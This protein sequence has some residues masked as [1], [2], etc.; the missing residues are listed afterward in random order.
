M[1]PI[2]N[3]ALSITNYIKDKYFTFDQEEF[4]NLYSDD[5][6]IEY[7]NVNQTNTFSGKSGCSDFY[8]M[9]KSFETPHIDGWNIQP[10]PDSNG[11]FQLT[12]FGTVKI[13]KVHKFISSFYISDN[14]IQQIAEIEFQNLKIF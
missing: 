5:V 11:W 7:T 14:V 9:L 12:I 3:D 2:S 8:G 1:E 10:L 4:I 6:K 13:S